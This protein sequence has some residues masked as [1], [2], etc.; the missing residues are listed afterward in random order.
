[1]PI[2]V[3]DEVIYQARRWQVVRVVPQAQNIEP[4]AYHRPDRLR[5]RRLGSTEAVWADALTVTPTGGR[6]AYGR[7]WGRFETPHD[8][9]TCR[10]GD[11]Y[12]QCSGVTPV[13]SDR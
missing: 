13:A 4:D 3:D 9:A 8:R 11:H 7:M 1:M 12:G 5:L 6:F 2:S 10:N